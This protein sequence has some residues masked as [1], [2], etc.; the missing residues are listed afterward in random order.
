MDKDGN[1][2]PTGHALRIWGNFLGKQMVMA[3]ATNPIISYASFSQEENKLYI[4]LINKSEIHYQFKLSIKGY[5]IKSIS[6]SWE[7]VGNSFDDMIPIWSKRT[8]LKK[9]QILKG[10]S[11]TVFE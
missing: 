4:Y 10:T 6:Q 3:E 11:I 2:N 7:Y 9:D 8:S 1:L 5:K